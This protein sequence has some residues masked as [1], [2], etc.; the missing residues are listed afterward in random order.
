MF[1][2]WKM[3][4]AEKCEAV[5]LRFESAGYKVCDIEKSKY[6]G[7][8]V[9]SKMFPVKPHN[10]GALNYKL[11][12]FGAKFADSKSVEKDKQVARFELLD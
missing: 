7:Y 6:R 3:T 2:N 5:K 11:N 4:D 9:T 8:V 10:N 1:I 12:R